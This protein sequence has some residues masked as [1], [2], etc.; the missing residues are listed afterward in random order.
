MAKRPLDPEE[1]AA[2]ER[3]KAT[4]KPLHP[5][6]T[7]PAVTHS[8]PP[9]ASL[10]KN[11]IA[12]RRARKQ[13]R[14]P[15]PKAAPIPVPPKPS[16]PEKG[17]DSHWDRRLKS[18]VVTP[19]YHLDLHGMN[20][21]HAYDRLDQALEQAVLTG[22]RTILLVT[23]KAREHDRASGQGRGAIRAAIHDWLNASRHAP[24]I[25]SVRGAHPRHGGAG[26]LY[27]ILK[28]GR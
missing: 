25:A 26:A 9:P 17:L 5:D 20:L 10:S 8:T 13:G 4:V 19:D 12:P 21:G 16:A 6:R 14:V 2:W 15:P 18:G 3:V 1:K 11:D 28:R 22:A 23:G 27:I 24:Y 7:P